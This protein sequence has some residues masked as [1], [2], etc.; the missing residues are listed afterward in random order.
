MRHDFFF[1][2]IS[3]KKE[4]E[5]EQKE[6]ATGLHCICQTLRDTKI[7]GALFS[8]AV[9]WVLKKHVVVCEILLTLSKGL[10]G[11][12]CFSNKGFPVSDI[13]LCMYFYCTCAV[14]KWNKRVTSTT[15]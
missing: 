5:E 15:T 1:R 3:G 13:R 4:K 6:E 12:S 7:L 10:Q 2:K 14:T 8:T 9:A 11:P